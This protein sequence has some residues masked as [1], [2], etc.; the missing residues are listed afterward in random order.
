ML[1]ESAMATIRDGAR[2]NRGRATAVASVLL[3]L[4]A[5]LAP[6]TAPSS[7]WP[8]SGT[9][10]APD[11]PDYQPVETGYPSSCSSQS[12][13]DEQLYFY[14]FM[15]K[16]APQAMDPENASGMS[17]STAWQDFGRLAIGRPDVV[18]AYI[19]GGINW[20]HGD[21]QELAKKVYL[22]RGELPPALCDRSPCANPGSYDANGDGVFNAADYEQ[23]SRVS[24]FNGNGLID[25]EDVITAFTCYDRATGN[26]GQLSFDVSNRQHCSNGDAVLAVDNDGNGYPHDISGW[27]FYDHQNDPATYDSAYGHANS[28]QKQAAAQTDNGVEGAGL[29][30]ECLL[31]PIKAG[32]EALDR[33]DDLA[34]AWLFAVDSGASVIT[35]VTADLG[36]TTFMRQAVEYAWRHGVVMAESSNDFDSTD[37]QG[38]MFWPHVLPG[39]GLVPNSNGLPAGLANAETTT[40]RARSGYT[41]WG[42]HNMFSVSTQG[43][44]TSESTPTVTGVMGLVLSF[45]RSISPV[46]TGPEAIQVVR[47]TA[48]RI[49]D[50]T[51]PWPGSPG[52]WNLQ[53]GYGRPN[54]DL[55]MRAIQARHI[56]PVAWIDSPDWYSLYDPTQT[57]A[58]T[59]SGHVEDRR[60]TSG[61]HWRLQYGLGPQPDTWTTFASGSGSKPKDV[62][63][64]LD[65][66]GIP[67]SFWDDAQ[68]PYR[69]SVTKTLETTEQY[70]VSLRLQVI[71]NANASQPW[72]TGEERRSIAVHHDPSLLPGFPL[73]LGHGGESQ[74]ALVDL[75]GTGHLD[76]VFGDSDGYVHAIDPITRREL[77]GWPVHT[78]PT[79]AVRAHAGVTPGYEP[80]LAP[81]AV[82]D[83]DHT[84]DLWV[85]ATSTRGKVYVF[86]ASGRLRQGWPRTLDLDVYVPPIPRAQLPFTRM[87]QLGS[88][89]SPVLYSLSGD[90]KL[91]VVQAA[92][93]G[94]IHIFNPDGSAYRNIQVTRPPDS[95]LDPGAHWINDHKLDSTPV[96]ANLDGHPDVVIRS[97]WTETTSTGDLAAGGAGFLHAYK[98]DGTLL[99]IAKM[100]S[101]VEYYGSAQEFLTEGAED[102]A[103]APVFPGGTDQVA[104]GPV[105]SPSYLFNS[106]GSNATVYGPLPGSPT[107]VFLQNA[108][109]CIAAPSSCSYSGAQLQSFLAGNLPADAPVF[110]TTGG[111]FGRLT[112]PGNLTYAQPGT[113]GA[114]LAAALLFSGSGFA[115]KNYVTD[116]DAATGA[117]MPGFAQQIQGLDFL[118]SPI[119][120]DVSGDGQPDLVVGADSSALMAYQAGGAMPGGFPKFTSGWA[121]WAPSSGDLLSDGHTD[122]VQ[123]TREGYVFA[124]RTDG[125]YAGDQE[126]WAG[127]HD[128][129]RT[130]R[131][132]VDSRPP[133]AIRNARL[134]GSKLTFTAPGGDWYDGQAA[135]YRVSFSSQTIPATVPAGSPQSITV[136]AGVTSFTIQAVDRAGNLGPALTVSRTGGGHGG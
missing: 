122:I 116:F 63:G 20:H 135:G 93:D 41:S 58:V 107:G 42:T 9:P 37:H 108:A 10:P 79:Q 12:V 18:I 74:A 54:V 16:C 76:V 92:W 11:D 109:A 117:S 3:L 1:V 31:L 5:V 8:T 119:V 126:W 57:G 51:L 38:S 46:L 40:Y 120:A 88:L 53:Y 106:D 94:Y 104:S 32:A 73:R 78:D 47:A 124:W 35:S 30:S 114:S 98:P 118:G 75:Q 13:D 62:S 97:Q 100:P 24:D 15:P 21:A 113:G 99:W 14:G 115:I 39:N 101:I 65:L 59:I 55:A 86:D 64:T 71:D 123:L 33:D 56:P 17:I 6:A 91:Q 77:P 43:G 19:E 111:V 87:P 72:G 27:D 48:S 68:N 25:P 84:G 130:G 81:V 95:E 89:S 4:S 102:E 36:Y 45:G 136:P 133:G 83:L 52:D 121:V 61:Y 132:G 128:E 129:W 112:I 50:P 29:C 66:S 28:Q 70:T 134:S 82:G 110:F 127:H 85:V 131:Y 80:I 44:T 90:G 2:G 7:G 96:I 67:A 105:L 69:M 60:S 49:T 26:L 23:D 103:A 125:T 22:N 34:Q